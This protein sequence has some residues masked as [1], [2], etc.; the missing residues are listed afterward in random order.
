M[1]AIL[2]RLVSTLTMALVAWT[3]FR[4]GPQNNAVISG[5]LHTAWRTETG[6]QISASPTV[7]DG[8]LYVGNNDGALYALDVASGQVLWSAHVPNPLMSA[9]L[10]YGDLVIVGEGD[11]TSRTSSPSEPVS[12]GQGP[13]A[14]VGFDRASGKVRWQTV[15]LG[16][17]MPTPAIINGVL[18]HHDGAGWINALDP[19]TG[20]KRY[21]HSIGSMASMTAMLPI[22]NGDFITAG[23]GANAVWRFHADDGA[24]VWR[25]A[26]SRGASGIGDCP[27]V[28]DGMRVFCDYISPVLP[29]TSTVIGNVAVERVYALNAWSGASA[30]DI[31]LESGSL[32]IRNEAAI[33]ML[34]GGL[35]YLGSAIAPWMHAIDA[36]S[37]MLVWEQPTRG[38]VKGGLVAVDGVI[39]FG[40]Y[41]GYLWALEA[42][43]GRV[44][45]DKLMH[46][47]FNVG[48]PIVV[49]RT[50]I[51]GSD[52]GSVIAV[53]L[54]TIRSSH[55]T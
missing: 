6:G 51:I 19:A 8:T 11:P 17:A 21:A 10:I 13:S 31:A 52:S 15:L 49:G 45:G 43:T 18:V 26:F 3:Q 39:Y 27:Q 22:G 36:T 34:D 33:P 46:T 16:S 50:L 30:W 5:D 24:L 29:D 41:G 1:S 53:P 40:D 4:L 2:E 20:E 47:P 54:T 9:P 55:D 44:I 23:V 12:V 32:P 35:L 38:V 14:L 48:S 25:S 37:G 28:T 7:A 42:K